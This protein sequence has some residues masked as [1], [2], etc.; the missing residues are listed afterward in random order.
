MARGTLSLACMPALGTLTNL[1]QTGELSVDEAS[2]VSNLSR[3]VSVDRPLTRVPSSSP[4]VFSPRLM[5]PQLMDACVAACKEIHTV[6]SEALLESASA[7]DAS[8]AS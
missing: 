6:V 7:R 1:S 4:P 8:V 2:E 5:N 3:R